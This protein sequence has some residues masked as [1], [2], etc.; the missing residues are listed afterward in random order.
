MHGYS[1]TCLLNCGLQVLLVMFYTV[2]NLYTLTFVTVHAQLTEY[3]R[4]FMVF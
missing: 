1:E 3:G 4:M 2:V